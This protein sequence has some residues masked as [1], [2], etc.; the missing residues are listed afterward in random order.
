MKLPSFVHLQTTGMLEI[1]KENKQIRCWR[2]LACALLMKYFTTK[3][4][5]VGP[6]KPRALY[7]KSDSSGTRACSL[8]LSI[9]GKSN[10]PEQRDRSNRDAIERRREW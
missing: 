7:G 8:S 9:F 10:H 6:L 1:T 5:A 3:S 2:P 4:I